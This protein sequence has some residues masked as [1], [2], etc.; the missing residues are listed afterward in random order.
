MLS[1][2]DGQQHL[3]P[4]YSRTKQRCPVKVKRDLSIY[5]RLQEQSALVALQLIQALDPQLHDAQ[6]GIS[7]LGVDDAAVTVTALLLLLV[8]HGTGLGAENAHAQLK[9]ALVEIVGLAGPLGVVGLGVAHAG[10]ERV[11]ARSDDAG[12]VQSEDVAGENIL[13][14]ERQPQSV[15]FRDKIWKPMDVCRNVVW[16]LRVQL[17]EKVLQRLGQH[18]WSDQT[19]GFDRSYRGRRRRLMLAS[20]FG[21]GALIRGLE[22]G[23]GELGRCVFKLLVRGHGLLA[24][25]CGMKLLGTEWEEESRRLDGSGGRQVECATH[26]SS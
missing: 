14:Q 2:C 18:Q 7:V 26:Q 6:D 17:R 15:A 19:S 9:Q 16:L 12:P 3:L 22:N 1:L 24:C 20:W 5:L 23:G 4:Y 21:D 11:V 10:L 8:H 25:G 13:H